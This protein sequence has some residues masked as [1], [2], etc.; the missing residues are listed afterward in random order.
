MVQRAACA[1][2]QDRAGMLF[3]RARGTDRHRDSGLVVRLPSWLHRHLVQVAAA[4]P[5]AGP[6]H[7]PAPAGVRDR[8]PD[9][10]SFGVRE[11]HRRHIHVTETAELEARCDMGQTQGIDES[12]FDQS[13][14]K[15]RVVSGKRRHQVAQREGIGDRADVTENV[16]PGGSL[17]R[18]GSLAPGSLFAGR[19]RIRRVLGSGGSGE[20]FEAL[21][22]T[23][24]SHVA[25]KVLF[26]GT[27]ESQFERTRRELS[28]VRSIHHPG[29]LRVWDIGE[30][31][32]LMFVVSELLAGE[33]LKSAL[34]RE[35]TLP[36]TEAERI[37]KELLD[38]LSVAHSQGIIHRDIKPANIFLAQPPDGSSGPP[39]VVLLDFGLAR[40]AGSS[41]L[42][43]AGRFMGTPEY[44][45]PEQVRGASQLTSACDLY[46]CGVTLWEML[47]G[48]P[49]FEGNSEIDT[50]TAHLAQPLPDP[51]RHLPGTKPE[52]R[53]LVSWLLEKDAA[54]RPASAAAASGLLERRDAAA[55]WRSLARS[56][57]RLRAWQMLSVGACLLAA[58]LPVTMYGLYP[59]S[60]EATEDGGVRWDTRSGVTVSRKVLGDGVAVAGLAGSWNG[61]SRSAWLVTDPGSAPER[62]REG[63]G[64]EGSF[65][66]QVATP[67]SSPRPVLQGGHGLLERQELYEGTDRPFTPSAIIDLSEHS[68]PGEA[69]LAVLVRQDPSYPSALLLIGEGDDPWVARYLHPG[70]IVDVTPY[71]SGDQAPLQLLVTAFNNHMAHRIVLFSV[72]ARRVAAGQA[73]PFDAVDHIAGFHSANWYRVLPEASHPIQ[74]DLQL[75]ASAARLLIAGERSS[76]FDPA[77]GVPLERWARDGL[78]ESEWI[79]GHQGAWR[80]MRR[81]SGLSRAG[82]PGAAARELEQLAEELTVPTELRGVLWW[83]AGREN[84]RAAEQGVTT[85]RS[86]Y[87]A[88]LADARRIAELDTEMPEA[89]LLEAEM[90]LRLG[91]IEELGKVF[92]RRA[93]VAKQHQDLRFSWY[94]INRLAGMVRP[95]ASV[96]NEWNEPLNADERLGHWGA[97]VHALEALREGRY[98]D[99]ARTAVAIRGDKAPWA[100][101]LYVKARALMKQPLPNAETVLS[102]LARAEEASSEG[103]RLPLA[104]ARARARSS[105]A[106]T[107]ATHDDME[108]AMEEVHRFEQL[109]RTDLPA[110]LML[111]FATADAAHVAREVG[112]EVLAERLEDR[113]R[114]SCFLPGGSCLPP[115]L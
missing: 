112:D 76:T 61:I 71:R 38:A 107:Q 19:Y 20:V 8:W 27:S 53:E 39:R 12:T 95:M 37:L 115:T 42:T 52:L 21:D 105:S 74:V 86:A 114:N 83:L 88:A 65:L 84:L 6:H 18:F 68:R 69:M 35:G 81:A 75:D 31:D 57:R 56:V 99:A 43:S 92:D 62:R 24:R 23:S 98:E 49:P 11:R 108:V 97:L 34:D 25:V 50:L 28:L 47:A 46:A 103:T 32:G 17:L 48:A 96:W 15:A 101:H 60:C 9:L 2:S 7:C 29:V 33:T 22:E 77:D 5:I 51:R 30:S 13:D 4:T 58:G 106:S 54:R 59:I 91:R 87:A 70:H 16:T 64:Q 80:G 36:V 109:A 110:M 40:R 78:T 89:Y 113:V 41:G 85:A 44:C 1:V 10:V 90:L 93:T 45:A 73:P 14:P 3:R 94:L 55:R 66:F 82:D 111:D 63:M 79:E 102:L 104:A 72:P 26:P 67:L 100:I